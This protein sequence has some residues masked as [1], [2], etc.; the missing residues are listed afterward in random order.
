MLKICDLVLF[1]L[2]QVRPTR[3]RIAAC[4]ELGEHARGVAARRRASEPFCWVA[5]TAREA[6]TDPDLYSASMYFQKLYVLSLARGRLHHAL[7]LTL[8]GAR[9]PCFDAALAC[10]AAAAEALLGCSAS[11]GP[12]ARLALA[13]ACLV[14]R[15]RLQRDAAFH[16]FRELC[17]TRSE[18]MQGRCRH[19]SE[20]NPRPSWR[21]SMPPCASSGRS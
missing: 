16:E 6:F 3:T 21:A 19:L 2:W 7:R 9:S 13:Y 17:K 12:A 18:L 15:E 20:L 11:A 14:A 4:F 1:A 5:A 10:H 8:A